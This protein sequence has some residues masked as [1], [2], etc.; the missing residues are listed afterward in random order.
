M[1]GA[2]LFILLLSIGVLFLL[3]RE[4]EAYTKSISLSRLLSA[5]ISGIVETACARDCVGAA[6]ARA[7]AAAGGNAPAELMVL[8][9]DFERQSAFFQNFRNMWLLTP[10]LIDD[11]AAFYADIA[12][13]RRDMAQCS[14]ALN[15]ENIHWLDCV[16]LW[17]RVESH[18]A[19]TSERLQEFARLSFF[20]WILARTRQYEPSLDI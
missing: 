18:G 3:K 13:L 5:E 1:R 6:Y 14:P 10:S 17:R 19:L 8:H 9:G 12:Q 4:H 15:L 16:R 20:K 2:I 11:V 7:A